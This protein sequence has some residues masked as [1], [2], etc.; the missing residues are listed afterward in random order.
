MT[1]ESHQMPWLLT[2]VDAY[3]K[4]GG[5]SPVRIRLSDRR[6]GSHPLNGSG[7]CGA[8]LPRRPAGFFALSDLMQGADHV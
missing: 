3:Q 6:S 4:V 5:V 1:G 2:V 8:F 7:G